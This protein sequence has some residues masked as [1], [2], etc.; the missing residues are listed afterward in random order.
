M[1]AAGLAVLTELNDISSLKGE[2]KK[3]KAIDVL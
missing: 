1:V 2:G 3:K